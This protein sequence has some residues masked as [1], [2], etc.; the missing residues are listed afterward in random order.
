VRWLRLNDAGL[1]ELSLI[2][3]VVSMTGSSFVELHWS[4]R[5]GRAQILDRGR[6]IIESFMKFQIC[7]Y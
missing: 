3:D 1:K 4:G 2:V 5:G 7:V 6:H